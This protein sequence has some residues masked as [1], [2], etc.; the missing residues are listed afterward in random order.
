MIVVCCWC[1]MMREA[2]DSTA[3]TT[4]RRRTD[5]CH[6]MPGRRAI[7]ICQEAAGPLPTVS[8]ACNQ[9]AGTGG[10][11]CMGCVCTRTMQRSSGAA[12]SGVSLPP[13]AA[14][15]RARLLWQCH[16]AKLLSAATLLL[17]VFFMTS[18]HSRHTTL[19]VDEGCC[20]LCVRAAAI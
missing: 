19:V 4:R 3:G 5:A 16:Q 11:G 10:C 1:V 20:S 6:A 14:A 2:G 13:S 12:R 7:A 15:A 9:A 18:S 8:A 17:S